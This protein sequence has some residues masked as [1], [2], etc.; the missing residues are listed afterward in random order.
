M[1]TRAEKKV[2]IAIDKM[3][4]L[5]DDFLIDGL[6]DQA[7]RIKDALNILESD[8]ANAKVKNGKIIRS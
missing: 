6:Y 8:I 3:V 2:Q 5:M 4:D 1:K 7:R